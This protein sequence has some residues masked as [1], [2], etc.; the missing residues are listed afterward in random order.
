MNKNIFISLG[1][2]LSIT[3][4]IW[5]VNH[6][7]VVTMTKEGKPVVGSIASPEITEN[8]ISVNGVTYWTL[9]MNMTSAT[10]SLCSFPN[11]AGLATTT[12]GNTGVTVPQ[13]GLAS[14][15]LLSVATQI[16]TGTSTAATFDIATG[17]SPWATS[18]PSFIY[19]VSIASGAIFSGNWPF[20]GTSTSTDTRLNA[21]MSPI[22]GTR[23]VVGPGEFVNV[24]TASAGLGGYTYGG[25]CIARFMS[26]NAF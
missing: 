20:E 4:S 12:I 6:K 19:G 7:Q 25:Q 16:T 26:L 14:S 13:V 21:S 11:P 10:T 15:T 9:K 3:L 22:L 24:K 8:H 2:A 18:T 1:I 23:Y 5:A 17:T